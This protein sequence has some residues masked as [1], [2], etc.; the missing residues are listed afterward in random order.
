MAAK[1]HPCHLSVPRLGDFCGK[2]AHF[3]TVSLA[4]CRGVIPVLGIERVLAEHMRGET[5]KFDSD[6]FPSMLSCGG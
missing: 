5:D 1:R 6:P 2:V 4:L 3:N